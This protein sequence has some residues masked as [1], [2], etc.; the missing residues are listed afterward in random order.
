M[1][2]KLELDKLSAR[3]YCQ[4]S[5]LLG[6]T[7]KLDLLQEVLGERVIGE[8]VTDGL[9]KELQIFGQII[10]YVLVVRNET[11]SVKNTFG[12]MTPLM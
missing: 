3:I 11:Q 4:T 12:S 1:A 10:L 9:D 6:D 7:V 5:N 8:V 2:K